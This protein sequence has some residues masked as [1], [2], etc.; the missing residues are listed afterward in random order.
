M[1]ERKDEEQQT[2]QQQ[3]Q[4]EPDRQEQA[5][6]EEQQD[7]Q[8]PP[9]EEEF[10]VPDQRLTAARKDAAR[11]RTRAHEA[12]ATATAANERVTELEEKLAG[13]RRERAIH[14]AM[15][16]H[17]LLK[18]QD[19][20]D[21]CTETDPDAITSWAERFSK[22]LQQSSNPNAYVNRLMRLDNS[23]GKPT[24]AV[25]NGMTRAVTAAVKRA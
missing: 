25:Q 11:Y 14:D 23:A 19:F 21:F 4:A 10:I 15:A 22:R 8:Q 12:E 2:D 1:T 16:A 9:H 20:V 3:M 6:P 18:A 24:I 13:L 5:T 7:E 17:P